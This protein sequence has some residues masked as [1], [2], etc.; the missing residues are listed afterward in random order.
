MF[1]KNKKHT[2]TKQLSTCTSTFHVPPSRNTECTFCSIQGGSTSKPI[3][4]PSVRLEF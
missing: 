2:T 1:V 3:S 4:R